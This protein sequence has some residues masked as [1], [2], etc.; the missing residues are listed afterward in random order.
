MMVRWAVEADENTAKLLDELRLLPMRERKKDI[1]VEKIVK[2]MYKT[3]FNS[4][5]S[6]E[7][8]AILGWQ[9]YE[10]ICIF[11]DM[12]ETLPE[13]REQYNEEVKKYGKPVLKHEDL[14]KYEQESKKVRKEIGL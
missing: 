8:L 3:W 13:L 5:N 7:K 4:N 12:L 11:C 9:E 10:S 6:I 2:E 1:R 14:E